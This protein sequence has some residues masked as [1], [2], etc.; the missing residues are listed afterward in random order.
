MAM[1]QFMGGEITLVTAG[2]AKRPM[3]DLPV[4]ARYMYLLPASFYLVAI[5]L[6]GLNVNYLDP[7][8]YHSHLSYVVDPRLE[9]IQTAARSPFVIVIQTAGIKVLPGFLNACFLLSA[10]TAA[11]KFHQR[12]IDRDSDKYRETH[13]RAHWQP[14]WAILGLTLC[15]LLMLFSGWAAIYDLCAGSRDVDWR[16]AVVDLAAAYLGPLMFFIILVVYKVTKKTRVRSIGDLRNVWFVREQ[17]ISDGMEDEV[18]GRRGR[19]RKPN[20]LREFLSWVR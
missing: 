7:R 11:I 14:L 6:L 15:S 8:L 18:R 10:L 12:S 3:R 17:G 9:G 5:L 16:D 13:Y 2:E 4:A 1:F 20:R 19:G